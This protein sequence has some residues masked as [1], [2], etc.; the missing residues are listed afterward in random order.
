MVLENLL[1]PKNL[2]HNKLNLIALGFLYASV[3]LFV[4]LLAWPS[5]SSLVLVFLTVMASM[6]FVYNLLKQEEQ[7]DKEIYEEKKLLKEHYKALKSLMFLFFGFTIGFVFWYSTLPTSLIT[8]S[9]AIQINVWQG[10]NSNVSGNAFLGM[11]D[12]LRVFLN[13]IKVL[14]FCILFAFLYGVGAI[15]ILVWN[16]SVIGIAIGDFI[17]REVSMIARKLHFTAVSD[18]FRII[19]TG[20]L[21][22]TLHGIP[23]ILAYFTGGMAGAIISIAVINHDFGT[24]KFE[25]ILVDSTDLI[26][27]AIGILIIAALIEVYITPAFKFFILGL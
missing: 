21:Q 18:Y 13:N 3:G 25:N 22:Y 24:E 11:E 1:Q 23:E 8:E 15:F 27:I 2:E 16:A 14:I 12:F 20:F 7:K 19:G 6:P 17:R 9:F 26:L 5:Q 10:L 4:G